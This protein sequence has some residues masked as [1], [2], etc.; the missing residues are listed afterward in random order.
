[1][2]EM[3]RMR[4]ET[5]VEYQHNLDEMAFNLAANVNKFHA[6]GTGINQQKI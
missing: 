1:M 3:L 4:D 6:T 5:I 2:S